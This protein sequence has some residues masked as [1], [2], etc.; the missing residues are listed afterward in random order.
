[1]LGIYFIL[2]YG[3]W[4]GANSISPIITKILM[5]YFSIS[6]AIAAWFCVGFMKE[7]NLSPTPET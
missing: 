1:M 7:N 6:V 2:R 4:F 3:D 5:G